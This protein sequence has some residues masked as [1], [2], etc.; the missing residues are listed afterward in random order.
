MV[1]PNIS[2]TY[3]DKSSQLEEDHQAIEVDLSAYS[4]LLSQEHPTPLREL[5]SVLVVLYT[6]GLTISKIYTKKVNVRSM[7][8]GLL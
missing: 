5:M 7:L 2:E 1:V 4:P 6:E 8:Q 3:L